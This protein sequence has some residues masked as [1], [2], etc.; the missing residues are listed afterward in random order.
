MVLLLERLF[1]SCLRH[2]ASPFSP[3]Q[4]RLSPALVGL[5][6]TISTALRLPVSIGSGAL[7]DRYGRAV[8]FIPGALLMALVSVVLTL[9]PNLG[10]N[11]FFRD[12]AIAG[13]TTAGVLLAGFAV[14][15]AG[16]AFLIGDTS[17]RAEAK[18]TAAQAKPPALR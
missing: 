6:I 17:P 12:L 8:V 2:A 1:P 14:F 3:A 5:A 18:R 16:L 15:A 10:T 7:S 13:Y 11:A 4:G 9:A